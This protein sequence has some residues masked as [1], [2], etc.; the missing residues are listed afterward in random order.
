[1]YVPLITAINL[2]ALE[3]QNTKLEFLCYIFYLCIS[4]LAILF[5]SCLRRIYHQWTLIKLAER[6]VLH[7]KNEFILL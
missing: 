1:M 5:C 4:F 6:V 3:I 2:I 7:V